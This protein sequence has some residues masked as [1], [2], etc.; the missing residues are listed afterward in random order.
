MEKK[1]CKGPEAERSPWDR[2]VAERRGCRCTE[3]RSEDFHKKISEGF[4][5]ANDII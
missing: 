5:L 2:Q 4:K 3:S 1:G